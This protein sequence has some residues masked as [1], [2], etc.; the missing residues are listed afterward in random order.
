MEQ[1][2]ALHVNSGGAQHDFAAKALT[3]AV[4]KCERSGVS[5]EVTV[6]TMVSVAVT[7]L[8][9]CADLDD[10]ATLLESIAAGI[11]RGD[12]TRDDA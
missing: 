1:K 3:D 4:K 6:E 11:R 2:M 9:S 7:L 10:A 8:L 12:F 5:T